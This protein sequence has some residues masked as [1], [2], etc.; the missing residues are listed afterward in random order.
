MEMVKVFLM[1]HDEDDDDSLEIG[2]IFLKMRVRLFSLL[3]IDLNDQH[4]SM[5]IVVDYWKQKW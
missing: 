5:V 3:L 2:S 4:L 1:N